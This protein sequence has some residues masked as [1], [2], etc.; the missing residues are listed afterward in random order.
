M[1]LLQ[2]ESTTAQFDLTLDLVEQKQ[3]M[4]CLLEYSTELFDRSTVQ[5]ILT[6]YTIILEGILANPQ[7]RLLELPLLTEEERQQMLVEWNDTERDHGHELSIHQ[8]FERQAER[9][10]K[11]IALIFGEERVSYAELNHRANQ[12]GHYL[13]GL[14]VGPETRAGILL[15]RS[16]EM[17]IAL[18]G[19][20]KAGGAYVAFDPAY[21]PE[22]LRYMLEDSGVSMLLT[23]QDVMSGQPELVQSFLMPRALRLAS[24]SHV[25]WRAEWM[26]RTS[27]T[28]SIRQGQPGDRKESSLSTAH[29]STRPTLSLTVID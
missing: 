22:R 16:V 12:L 11:A 6:H 8:L 21:P 17:A 3:G 5:R 10:P 4:E 7:Q 18:L 14:G 20:L 23:M 2:D 1:T 19:V 24:A 28:W 9:T 25:M 13:K 26:P 29:W 15:E 27:F